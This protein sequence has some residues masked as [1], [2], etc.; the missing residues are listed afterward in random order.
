MQGTSE[1]KVG[2]IMA[3]TKFVNVYKCRLCGEMFTSSGPDGHLLHGWGVQG[4]CACRK[5]DG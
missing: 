5:L 4:C 1:R 2:L 3:L